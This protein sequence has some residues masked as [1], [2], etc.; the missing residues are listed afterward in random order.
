MR[1]SLLAPSLA[2]AIVVASVMVVTAT[3]TSITPS[4]Q[5]HAHGVQSNWLAS[6]TG[7]SP[8][9][10]TWCYVN[11]VSCNAPFQTGSTSKLYSHAFYP[12]TTTTFTQKL[13][14]IDFLGNGSTRYSSATEYGG[15]PC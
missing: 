4:S 10:V 14:V 9:T 3:T 8:Y 11:G 2:A 5:T 6:W 7:E 15:N 1:K 12:C 13:Y